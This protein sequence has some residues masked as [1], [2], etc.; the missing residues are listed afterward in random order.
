MKKKIL[1]IDQGEHIGGAEIF[2]S[3]LLEHLTPFHEVHLITS[4]NLAYHQ[5]YHSVTLHCLELPPLRPWKL[6]SYFSIQDS[7][8]NIIDEVKPDVIISNTVR[9]HLLVSKLAHEKR[10]PLL[11][12]AH[13]F[14]FPKI[15][16]RYFIHFPKAVICCS[17]AVAAFYDFVSSSAKTVCLYPFALDSVNSFSSEKKKIIGM[18][19]RAIPWKGQDIFIRVARRLSPEFP[20][21]EWRLI[22]S[23][24]E[25][26]ISSKRF[27]ESLLALAKG[28]PSFHFLPQVPD[29]LDELSAWDVFVHCSREPEPLGRVIM[30]A[31]SSGCAVIAGNL[32]GPKEIIDPNRTGLLI[33]PDEDALEKAIKKL[34]SDPPFMQKLQRNAHEYYNK[35]FSWK[36]LMSRFQALL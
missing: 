8:R 20:D 24:Y 36:E 15:L 17:K 23:L 31:M 27:Y 11:W 28:I 18:I 1:C 4:H 34:L 7:V 6:L 32:G 21:Y 33:H 25:G 2:F 12:M 10:I 19:G 5:R 30:E 29:V 26:N 35:T 22:T 9:T 3:E 16:L 14:T 13:D